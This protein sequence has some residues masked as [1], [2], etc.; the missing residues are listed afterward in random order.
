MLSGIC[1]RITKRHRRGSE[2]SVGVPN[3]GHTEPAGGS[4]SACAATGSDHSAQQSQ[5]IDPAFCQKWERRKACIET[6]LH[7]SKARHTSGCSDGNSV[8][9]EIGIDIFFRSLCIFFR[10]P[11]ADKMVFRLR[12]RWSTD[13]FGSIAE[14]ACE[15][16]DARTE[17]P[18]GTPVLKTCGPARSVS[19]L[20]VWGPAWVGSWRC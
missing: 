14:L 12:C 3:C 5:A 20:A 4:V 2:R 10:C 9:C 6:P 18:A 16:P 15:D 7:E 19:R 11:S 13:C 8:G 1:K 17:T